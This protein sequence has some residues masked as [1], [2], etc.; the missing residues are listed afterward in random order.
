MHYTLRGTWVV[1]DAERR[2]GRRTIQ[3]SVWWDA[4]ADRLLVLVQH[5]QQAAA[6]EGDPHAL[7]L[8]YR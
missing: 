7:L 2:N 5:P 3:L 6:G 8:R 4:E 1:H